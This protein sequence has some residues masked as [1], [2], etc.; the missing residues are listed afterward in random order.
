MRHGH[1]LALNERAND[2]ARAHR[3]H[4]IPAGCWH[5]QHQAEPRYLTHHA[6]R[7][8]RDFTPR[9]HYRPRRAA[10]SR[11]QRG[12][13]DRQLAHPT[14]VTS[15]REFS[16]RGA[17]RFLRFC[18][19]AWSASVPHQTPKPVSE[20]TIEDIQAWHSDFRR[21]RIM[22]TL[23]KNIPDWAAW[24][25]CADMHE[26]R[27]FD[28]TKGFNMPSESEEPDL[29]FHG[30]PHCMGFNVFSWRQE[31][32]F[33]PCF[34]VPTG[35]S[36][37]CPPCNEIQQ[38]ATDDGEAML[39]VD[40]MPAA[41]AAFHHAKARA[42]MKG[43]IT[44]G[45]K[46]EFDEASTRIGAAALSHRPIQE[47]QDLQFFKVVKMLL[48]DTKMIYSDGGKGGRSYIRFPVHETAIRRYIQLGMHLLLLLAATSSTSAMR[49]YWSTLSTT[50]AD[51]MAASSTSSAISP[52]AAIE[53]AE[54]VV[55][56]LREV[57]RSFP[58]PALGMDRLTDGVQL[59]AAWAA[60]DLRRGIPAGHDQ[61][62]DGDYIDSRAVAAAFR[63]AMT[64]HVDG[65]LFASAI[66]RS[67]SRTGPLRATGPSSAT[68][69]AL[70]A[71]NV[72]SSEATESILH[73]IG[74]GQPMAGIVRDYT[75]SSNSDD[76]RVNSARRSDAIP[77]PE[78]LLS[79]GS[80]DPSSEELPPPVIG[81]ISTRVI[82]TATADLRRDGDTR[83]HSPH[84]VNVGGSVL[85]V[86]GTSPPPSPVV[87][88]SAA[89]DPSTS[90]PPSPDLGGWYHHRGG[91]TGDAQANRAEPSGRPTSSSERY[92]Q[93][94]STPPPSI[95]PPSSN[96]SADDTDDGG[97]DKYADS[98]DAGR[99]SESGD[100]ADG[101]DPSSDDVPDLLS[102]SD[103][104]SSGSE[105]GSGGGDQPHSYTG[106]GQTR[107]RV[108]W[109]QGIAT[110]ARP[111]DGNSPLGTPPTQ[112]D[113]TSGGVGLADGYFGL[114][115]DPHFAGESRVDRAATEPDPTRRHDGDGTATSQEELTQPFTAAQ[116]P[117]PIE[118]TPTDS[119]SARD[120]RAH[121]SPPA[122]AD[123][124]PPS[125]TSAT[126]PSIPH[127]RDPKRR[128]QT[129]SDSDGSSS[130][131]A[132][133][134]I[135]SSDETVYGVQHGRSVG[136]HLLWSSC[137]KSVHKF[138]GAKFW[139]FPSRA[140][141]VA[142]MRRILGEEP[143]VWDEDEPEPDKTLLDRTVLLTRH[144]AQAY[145]KLTSYAIS[146][147]GSIS[148]NAIA[149]DRDNRE[150]RHVATQREAQST[151]LDGTRTPLL[152]KDLHAAETFGD[153]VFF[154]AVMAT[155]ANK[156]AA[157]KHRNRTKLDYFEMWLSRHYRVEPATPAG[158]RKPR[159]KRSSN[160][161]A[162]REKSSGQLRI[163][164][165]RFVFG[166]ATRSQPPTTTV[167]AAAMTMEAMMDAA[168][169][170]WPQWPPG[171]RYVSAAGAQ[172]YVTVAS[173]ADVRGLP[174]GA[175]LTLRNATRP[176]DPPAPIRRKRLQLA[177]AVGSHTPTTRIVI[178]PQTFSTLLA[179]SG[180]H[181]QAWPA[182]NRRMVVHVA[183]PRQRCIFTDVDVKALREDTTITLA[184]SRR[185]K[186]VFPPDTLPAVK[187][188]PASGTA[189]G[190]F[191][192]FSGR[193]ISSLLDAATASW[194]QWPTQA[195]TMSR[196]DG[197]IIAADTDVSTLRYGATVVLG[198]TESHSG[199]T[200]F[201]AISAGPRPGVYPA[202]RAE[203]L[204]QQSEAGTG[205]VTWDE[206]DDI[207]AAEQ[208]LEAGPRYTRT[209]TGSFEP[210]YNC[211][212]GRG[213]D[214]SGSAGPSRTASAR[215][216]GAPSDRPGRQRR[217]ERITIAGRASQDCAQPGCWNRL[218][219]HRPHGSFCSRHAAVATARPPER[220]HCLRPRCDNATY[221]HTPGK[222]SSYCGSVCA[223]E[224]AADARPSRSDVPAASDAARERS[225]TERPSPGNHDSQAKP[226][227]IPPAENRSAHARPPVSAAAL[228]TKT[229][230]GVTIPDPA[231]LL[232]NANPDRVAVYGVRFYG[233]MQYT[234]G[235]RGAVILA[236]SQ[237]DRHPGRQR[238]SPAP[239]LFDRFSPMMANVEQAY[240]W[241]REQAEEDAAARRILGL[242]EPGAL[243]DQPSAG[244]R[245]PARRPSGQG[246]TSR[247][248]RRPPQHNRVRSRS[249]S[250]A[251]QQWTS[252]DDGSDRAAHRPA[253]RSQSPPARAQ[254]AR[255][256][257]SPPAPHARYR[258][259]R[260][261]DRHQSRRSGAGPGDPAPGTDRRASRGPD[262]FGTGQEHSHTRV[263]RH[264][265]SGDESASYSGAGRGGGSHRLLSRFSVTFGRKRRR[266]LR[267][268]LSDDR[269]I[270][271]VSDPS[272]VPT[273]HELRELPQPGASS[274]LTSSD[275]SRQMLT[276]NAITGSAEIAPK[277]VVAPDVEDYMGIM[278]TIQL[279]RDAVSGRDDRVSMSILGAMDTLMRT[280][281]RMYTTMKEA[282]TL[283]NNES[284]FNVLFY[285]RYM[286]AAMFRIVFDH[287]VAEFIMTGY[288]GAF[289][290]RIAARSAAASQPGRAA[291]STA[292]KAGAFTGCYV[293]GGAHRPRDE[294][295][296]EFDSTAGIV[297]TS[298]RKA[299]VRAAISAANLTSA[300]K[301]EACERAEKY[302]ISIQK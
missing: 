195:R 171:N 38:R 287:A 149:R 25:P 182:R 83:S 173:D 232:R 147:R 165:R 15:T 169:Q 186:L 227:A 128:R 167:T 247:Q 248:Q 10:G 26:L 163:L 200:R 20:V 39:V 102:D 97:S 162:R 278:Q 119:A 66:N 189:R 30:K 55:N 24:T 95:I 254:A 121:G 218:S 243:R 50:A 215:S 203:L 228:P 69:P 158:A 11:T 183:T 258:D 295:A 144:G 80:Q 235:A 46:D 91:E 68:D 211:V 47:E 249:P 193:T 241:I 85:V 81:D 27:S 101:G 142:A 184:N 177:R 5:A 29:R 70:P 16:S 92:D 286:Y 176:R 75:P 98:G 71:N 271:I 58:N 122:T 143:F 154:A 217:Y 117:E 141:A 288:A 269:P 94:A 226:T 264:P 289:A 294:H 284:T 57:T 96:D 201:M 234:T 82:D 135:E 41:G 45:L 86:R 123:P 100:A 194:P 106:P 150:I 6:S 266:V 260:A 259:G 263:H 138:R 33:H 32:T 262:P 274:G 244:H 72:S 290:P 157:L 272:V 285:I 126:Q 43:F 283:G 77:R 1:D 107:R 12:R 7:V 125:A 242:S 35:D 132:R 42:L 113:D 299:A 160:R 105:S 202:G 279:T 67:V 44:A 23:L 4:R 166:R 199:P 93:R 204:R 205:A 255:R 181:W 22:V 90:P 221:E 268:F 188:V 301:R 253:R 3:P 170:H 51:I 180:Q 134:R 79:S 56:E 153:D 120:R 89:A 61:E 238:D 270:R 60:S 137:F 136:I 103:S 174:D 230:D 256:S 220:R 246:P 148:W 212:A 13:R 139:K 62:S 2:H 164:R 250:P 18:L 282:G 197:T 127:R 112:R 110:A 175:V 161:P 198:N 152:A 214:A 267:L 65:P 40:D 275:P 300:L 78:V 9:I 273:P 145:A 302:W 207:R 140:D 21:S 84:Q 206:F 251:R 99:G 34:A 265:E 87:L 129:G 222:F 172:G 257:R 37:R 216:T 151:V 14:Y 192:M 179:A 28:M 292:A 240:Y 229:I 156:A 114:D 168:V 190:P 133:P 54:I 178:A 124:T 88:G 104:S 210:I 187:F 115:D 224:A 223:A 280:T 213:P 53:A 17:R 8:R 293:C 111:A 233:P 59:L 196:L 261:P 116:P 108:S 219:Q 281:V 298:A 225:R 36:S 245:D 191:F 276:F 297:M 130:S 208:F 131:T 231:E 209:P 296:T 236:R 48:I 291:K 237:A 239:R 63:K 252:R 277:S 31:L 76:R 159:R 185:G 155:P 73:L 109:G 19:A 49:K 74:K 118:S 52:R 146:A 64:P